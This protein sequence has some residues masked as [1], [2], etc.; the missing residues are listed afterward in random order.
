MCTLKSQTFSTQEHIL[1]SA[2]VLFR[3][4]KVKQSQNFH[5][6]VDE[7]KQYKA[8]QSKCPFFLHFNKYYMF[9]SYLFARGR[10]STN[11]DKVIK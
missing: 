4:Q 11:K 8:E 2:I 5:F 1:Q 3:T 9:H 6:S 10:N 7:N